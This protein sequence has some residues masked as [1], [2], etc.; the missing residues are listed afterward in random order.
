M[1]LNPMGEQRIM[2]WGCLYT[3]AASHCWRAFP[4]KYYFWL[5][6][7]VTG[8]FSDSDCKCWQLEVGPEGNKTV[9]TQGIWLRDQQHLLK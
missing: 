3:N 9:R 4:R 7:P 5:F 6:Q 8:I 1:E 2:E